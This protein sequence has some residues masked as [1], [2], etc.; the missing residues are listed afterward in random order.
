MSNIFR[1]LFIPQETEYFVVNHNFIIQETSAAVQRFADLHGGQ[2]EFSSE[3]G[4]G[5]TFIV[6]IP[7]D[8]QTQID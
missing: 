1:K 2:I 4:L 3:P 8:K 5:T 6:T 7:F